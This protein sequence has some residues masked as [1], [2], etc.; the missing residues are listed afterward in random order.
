MRKTETTF[1]FALPRLFARG[2]GANDSRTEMNWLEANVVGTAVHG[3]A[4]L[5]AAHFFLRGLTLGA[6]AL[7]L[8]PLAAGVWL[9]WLV[10]LYVNSLLIRLLRTGGLLRGLPD[11][12]AQSVLIGGMITGFAI[13]LWRADSWCSFAGGIWLAAVVLNLAAALALVLLSRNGTAAA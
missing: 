5:F 7:L 9:A 12:R 1:Y 11:D 3:I 6:Q 2:R 10:I 8:L 4:Y 13:A